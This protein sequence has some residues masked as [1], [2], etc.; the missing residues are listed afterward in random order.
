MS[1]QGGFL[2]VLFLV[3]IEFDEGYNVERLDI[4]SSFTE[5]NHC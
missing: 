3:Y 4:S 5:A 2:W 1:I